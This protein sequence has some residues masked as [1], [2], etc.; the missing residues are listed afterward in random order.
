VVKGVFSVVS[1]P[2]PF[3]PSFFYLCTRERLSS[4][5]F[6]FGLVMGYPG[7]RLI[8]NLLPFDTN[9]AGEPTGACRFPFFLVFFSALSQ[10][11]A[12]RH[13]PWIRLFFFF[14]RKYFF[15]T[16]SLH[17]GRVQPPSP[18]GFLLFEKPPPRVPCSLPGAH[19]FPPPSP[20]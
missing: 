1:T 18:T 15:G 17:L 11:F 10:L 6:F 13:T 20:A 12:T 9:N 3:P 19:R 16:P 7:R 5:M 4:A 2:R 14:Q 8:R